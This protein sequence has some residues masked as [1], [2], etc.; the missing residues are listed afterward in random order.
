[1]RDEWKDF[2]DGYSVTLYCERVTEEDVEHGDSGETDV[3]CQDD[4]E[5]TLMDI[6]CRFGDHSWANWSCS[7][8]ELQSDPLLRRSRRYQGYKPWLI[9]EGEI[10]WVVGGGVTEQY[11]L[12]IERQD[13]FP[14]SKA[15]YRFLN[16]HLNL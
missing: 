7:E 16:H 15:E 1:M 12:F 8:P 11:A 6:V 14:L 4:A 5:E 10:D 9:S 13:G 3:V 2:S